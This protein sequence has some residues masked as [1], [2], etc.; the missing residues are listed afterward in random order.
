[1]FKSKRNR[2]ISLVTGFF[3]VISLISIK[4]FN[5]NANDILIN[6][7]F[8]I[9]N[10][11]DTNNTANLIE[12]ALPKI[13]ANLI[14][15]KEIE[16]SGDKEITLQYEITPEDYFEDNLSTGDTSK[17]EEILIISD[18]SQKMSWGNRFSI[19]QNGLTN[20]IL[21]N[22]KFSSVKFGF[23]GYNEKYYIGDRNR[24]N[25]PK[26]VSMKENA[27]V[28]NLL[29]P[30]FDIS[31]GNSKDG[32]RQLLQWGK[33]TFSQNNIRNIDNALIKAKDIFDKYGKDGSGK[34][35][36][37]INAGDVN[38]SSEVA[39]IIKS[40][41]YKI[42]SLDIS[43]E[44]NTNLKKLHEDLGGVY[45]SEESKSD[46]L[47]GKLDGGNYN[48]VDNDMSK[49][50][51]KLNQ[52]VTV[53]K[54]ISIIP[55]LYFDL[56]NN[57]QYVDGSAEGIKV[58]N[59]SGNM[60]DFNLMT[61]IK[62]SYSGSMENGKYRYTAP[63]QVVSFKVKVRS[64]KDGVLTFGDNSV[65]KL[66][67][68]MSYLKFNNLEKKIALDTPIIIIQGSKIKNH[69][70]YNGI[71]NGEVIIEEN[72]NEVF[73][74]APNSTVTFGSEL[75]LIGDKANIS[76]NIDS[77]LLVDSQEIKVYKVVNNQLSEVINKYIINNGNNN[78]NI[79]IEGF[80]DNGVEETRVLVIYRGVLDDGD[81]QNIKNT[82]TI[83]NISR[84]VN[85][86]TTSS[87]NEGQRLPNLF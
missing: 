34:A 85:I 10:L 87:S 26:D 66:S 48:N 43:D 84:E 49:V 80:K 83:N 42:I 27:D 77:N 20:Q 28:N 30:L 11:N 67:N 39:N 8:E 52:G 5:A 23:I 18:L 12:E 31:D 58:E 41:G 70:L 55:K 63:K 22:S 17:I 59:N 9:I 62:Y 78:Y 3:L 71:S 81:N 51:D 25:D 4:T 15:N 56:N 64:D 2:I 46:Y 65:D 16:V 13:T 57:F 1:M 21:N 72:N 54:V 29:T 73:I 74:L 19:L 68:Y 6:P 45:S 60:L 7:N 79:S 69:G 40:Q 14:S 82:I 35:I 38:Y 86:T 47:V 36:I 32:F 61:P 76:L 33:V 75:I 37:L 53:D 44:K 24:I 50:A